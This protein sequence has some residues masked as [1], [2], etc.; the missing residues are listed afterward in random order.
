MFELLFKSKESLFSPF[1]KEM[2]GPRDE[3]MQWIKSDRERQILCYFTY[4]WILKNNT[5]K[6]IYK[7]E[8]DLQKQKTI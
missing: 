3:Y 6:L 4:K 8:T 1:G 2:R 5:N 7:P